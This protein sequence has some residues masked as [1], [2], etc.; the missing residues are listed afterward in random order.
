MKKNISIIVLFCYSLLLQGQERVL[1]VSLD[2][3]VPYDTLKCTAVM[4]Y[5]DNLECLGK[6]NTHANSWYFHLPDTFLEK[7]QYIRL[8]ATQ[9][10]KPEIKKNVR[11][12]EL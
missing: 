8:S 4:E 2:G 12:L 7:S 1:K 9:K 5:A 6:W 10:D 3:I 11:F